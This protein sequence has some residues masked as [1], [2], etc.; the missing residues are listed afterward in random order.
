MTSVENTIESH[1]NSTLEI[2]WIMEMDTQCPGS[3]ELQ[4]IFGGPSENGFGSAAFM[5]LA[6]EAKGTHTSLSDQAKLVYQRF[7]GDAWDRFGANHWLAGWKKSFHRQA[8]ETTDFLLEIKSSEY[9]NL[10]RLLGVLIEGHENPEEALRALQ[11]TFNAR[12]VASFEAFEVGDNEAMSGLILAA[13]FQSGGRSYLI[14][15]MD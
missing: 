7:L 5:F 2:A 13:E 4:S 1:K 15:L 8:A 11:T 3:E 10:R 12:S 14:F 9:A 6:P